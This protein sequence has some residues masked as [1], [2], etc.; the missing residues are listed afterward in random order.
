MAPNE[1]TV[2]T[3]LKSHFASGIT[4]AERRM[5]RFALFH[6][7]CNAA[8]SGCAGGAG[9]GFV[10]ANAGVTRTRVTSE[11]VNVRR[12]DLPLVE[13]NPVLRV[14]RPSVLRTRAYQAIVGELFEDVC[15][16]A[17]DSGHRKNRRIQVN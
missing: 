1:R 11:T 8:V 2:G 5:L 17:A 10:C 3:G 16:P 7:A 4:S 13:W 15:R 6:S 12:I 14:R 9:A